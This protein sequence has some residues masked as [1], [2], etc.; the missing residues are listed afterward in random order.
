[1]KPEVIKTEIL[2]AVRAIPKAYRKDRVVK[3]TIRCVLYRLLI[4]KGYQPVP[5]LRKP[6][7]P[8][9]PV[10]IAGLGADGAVKIAFCSNPTVELE[11]VKSLERLD[12]ERKVLITFSPAKKKVDMSTFFLKKGL[13]HLYIYDDG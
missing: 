3:E 8:E 12:P 7:F 1:M 4:E 2:K 11:D 9:G 6:S 5:C 10:D 13:E